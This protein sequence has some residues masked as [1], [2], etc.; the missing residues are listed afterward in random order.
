MS[1]QI[2]LFNPIFLK[3]KKH[4]S[5]VTML[6]ALGLIIVGSM[7]FYAYA[8]YQVH[9]MGLQKQAMTTR[10]EAEQRRFAEYANQF[11]PS[12]ANEILNEELAILEAQSAKQNELIDTL[13]SGAIGNTR[14]YSEFMRAFSRQ[15]VNGLWLTGFDIKGDGATMGIKGATTNPQSLPIF[16]QRMNKEEIMRGKTFAVLQ[17][18]QSTGGEDKSSANSYLE[19]TLQSSA[20]TEQ[21]GER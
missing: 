18:R 8:R 6:Q 7:L 17:M 11:S 20:I 14:G 12:R 21:G 9:Q 15:A 3:Q 2:N 5:L 10:Y 13:K 1:Q 4:F 16:I 19:F